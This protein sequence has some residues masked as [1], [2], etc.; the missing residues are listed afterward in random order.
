M[1][2]LE[3]NALISNRKTFFVILLLLALTVSTSSADYEVYHWVDENGVPNFSQDRP[4]AKT[5]GVRKLKLPDAPPPGQD[6][7]EEVYD[8]EAHAERMAA[9]RDEREQQ[10]AAAL[11]R[12]RLASLQQPVQ[13]AQPV[14]YYSRPIGYPPLYHRPKP[15]PRPPVAEPLPSSTLKL[16]GGK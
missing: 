2:R 10:R 7:E 8:V 4:T 16:P 12:Q 3:R 11:E 13:V 9:L 6:P 5:P 1:N 15:K 14:R